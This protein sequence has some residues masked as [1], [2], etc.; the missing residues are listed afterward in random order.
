MVLW[1]RCKHIE[2][3]FPYT[4]A[5]KC[6][7]TV[8][9]LSILHLVT[10]L[11]QLAKP[12]AAVPTLPV[13]YPCAPGY[14][15]EA[16]GSC[17]ICPPGTATNI[18]LL[19]CDPCPPGTISPYEGV[20]STSLCQPCPRKFA[21]VNGG[22]KCEQCDRGQ[23]SVGQ[24]R[25]LNCRKGRRITE[26]GRCERCDYF[27][28]STSAN[29][30]ECTPCPDGL[31]PNGKHIK[32]IRRNCSISH[33]WTVVQEGGSLKG[34]CR[35]CP[36]NSF[37]L[38]SMPECQQCMPYEVAYP[39]HKP[40]KCLRCPPGTFVAGLQ[41][42]KVR[43]S[44]EPW[45]TPEPSPF[46]SGED[47]Y[48]F[49]QDSRSCVPC[50]PNTTTFGRSKAAC[51]VIDEPCPPGTFEDADGD[52][53]R[54]V[55]NTRRS[56]SRG[57][58]I[59]CPENHVS[60][61]GTSTE[62]KSCPQNSIIINGRCDCAPGHVFQSG[63][64]VPCPA[65]T[66]RTPEGNPLFSDNACLFCPSTSFSSA[67]AGSCTACPEGSSSA[68][69]GGQRCVTLPSCEPGYVIPNDDLEMWTQA[70]TCVSAIT[71]CPKGL[72]N[73]GVW[74]TTSCFDESKDEFVCAAGWLPT[75]S[76]TGPACV[77]CKYGIATFDT[78]SNTWSCD[79]CDWDEIRVGGFYGSCKQCQN[80]FIPDPSGT[81]VCVCPE[82]WYIDSGQC[83]PCPLSLPFELL[84]TECL[85]HLLL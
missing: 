61:G 73:A 71:G 68:A 66:Y 55:R 53:Q 83:L 50:P 39:P 8:T 70:A 67:G 30:R 5:W 37:R 27:S 2:S 34:A 38:K 31:Y 7:R 74:G 75:Q 22:T 81:S 43:S 64:C 29:S 48:F 46:I 49:N 80:G 15:V 51:R 69:T 28:I 20:T 12:V 57:A 18:P 78:A 33:T 59:A 76:L 45:I 21:A 9:V 36:P 17:T 26:L 10:I 35:K 24:G 13:P 40:R 1:R 4:S 82:G 19:G 56:V 32:C 44:P 16:N 63:K 41:E 11:L 6:F 14:K 25:C 47:D 72:V 84:P 58:C 79:E 52:C 3:S 23:V 54:C 85:F 65:G 60:I 77:D 42:P 62:C